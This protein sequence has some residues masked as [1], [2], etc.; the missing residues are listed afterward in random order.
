[1]TRR[2]ILTNLDAFLQGQTI[3]EVYELPG[4]V[5]VRKGAAWQ[6][7]PSSVAPTEHLE[8]CCLI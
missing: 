5:G 6:R 7:Q 4:K 8:A 1:M 3:P 2:V